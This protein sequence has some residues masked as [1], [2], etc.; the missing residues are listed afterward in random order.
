ME[1][2]R[3]AGQATHDTMAHALGMLDNKGYKHTHSEY[4]TIN[5]IPR[6]QWLRERAP[7]LHYT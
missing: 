4:V 2:Y 1:K 7:V 6:L 5:V 3:R